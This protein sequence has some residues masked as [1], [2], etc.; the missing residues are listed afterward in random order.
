MTCVPF[1]LC[2]LS[3]DSHDCQE[4]EPRDIN[5]RNKISSSQ[6]QTREKH[7]TSS[8]TSVITGIE[9]RREGGREG[10]REEGRE[11][12]REERERERERER[13]GIYRDIHSVGQKIRFKINHPK[14]S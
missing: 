10:Y 3:S 1:N 5:M 4:A 6:R 7:L 9:V 11:G 2:H 12:D 13:E 14:N 8:V